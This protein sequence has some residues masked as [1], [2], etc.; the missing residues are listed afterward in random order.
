MAAFEKER[1][2][3]RFFSLSTDAWPSPPGG[4]PTGSMLSYIDTGDRFIYDADGQTWHIFIGQNDDWIDLLEDIRDYLAEMV[5]D[6][7]I[8]RKALAAMSNDQVDTLFPTD[9]E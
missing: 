7:D 1:G 5:L 4:V 9:D 6:V 8:A 2:A 3:R